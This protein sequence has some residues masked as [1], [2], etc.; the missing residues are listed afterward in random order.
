M[1]S[2]FPTPRCALQRD[3][4]QALRGYS[5]RT[6]TQRLTQGTP[7][8]VL[9]LPFELRQRSRLRT[10]LDS[11]EEI[12]LFLPRGSVLRDGDLL[13]N[14]DG[15]ILVIRAAPERVS[16][17]ASSDPLLL[18]RACYHLG[19]RHVLLQIGKTWLRYERDHVLDDMLRQLGLS[20]TWEEAPFEPEAGAYE[21]HPGHSHPVSGALK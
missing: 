4:E 11:G 10:I 16:L 14:E 17:A 8:A 12:G 21:Q 19:N 1:L 18:A 5:V 20:V 7:T 3:R 9:H 2:P 6:F 13:G 15:A